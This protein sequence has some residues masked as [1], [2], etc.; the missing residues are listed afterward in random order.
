MDPTIY[1]ME[2]SPGSDR[3]SEIAVT[4]LMQALQADPVWGGL[5][6]ATQMRTAA[7]G[8]LRVRRAAEEGRF[9]DDR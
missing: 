6:T 4:T 9:D 8:L 1:D 7:V 5:S 3:P 2:S